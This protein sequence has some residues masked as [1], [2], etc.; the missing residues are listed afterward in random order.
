MLIRNDQQKVMSQKAHASFEGRAFEYLAPRVRRPAT[1]EADEELRQDIKRG[2]GDAKAVNITRE[3]DTIR[4]LELTLGLG[5]TR[6]E[7]PRF[8]WVDDY[9]REQIPAGERLDL[10]AERLM[11]DTELRR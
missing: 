6:L 5:K 7:E 10:I 8:Q 1:P 9:L 4:Y 11:F 3:V 2:I